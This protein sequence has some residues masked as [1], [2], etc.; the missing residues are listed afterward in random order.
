MFFRAFLAPLIPGLLIAGCSAPASYPSLLPRAAESQSLEEPAASPPEPSAPDPAVEAKIAAAMRTLEERTTAFDGASSRAE[1]LV[2]AARGSAAGSEAW[3]DAHVALAE[4]D[5]LRSATS[6]IAVTL[7]DL[8][9]ERA[10]S[11]AP[12]YEPLTNAAD[13][14]RAAVASQAERIAAMQ[15]RL[16]PA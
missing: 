9:S 7:D 14:V 4:L 12:D 8:A 5:A 10:L 11:L 1:R 6:E 16:A 15:A 2:T 3:L 13:R